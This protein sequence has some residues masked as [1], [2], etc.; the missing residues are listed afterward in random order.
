MKVNLYKP[1]KQQNLINLPFSKLAVLNS[2]N[3]IHKGF[4]FPRT[5]RTIYT[6]EPMG[7]QGYVR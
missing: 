5:F 1:T 6:R 4:S 3:N 7:E 2:C